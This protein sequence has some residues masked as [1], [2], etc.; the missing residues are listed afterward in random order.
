M[1]YVISSVSKQK[2][3]GLN[4][5]VNPFLIRIPVYPIPDIVSVLY[6]VIRKS[7]TGNGSSKFANDQMKPD[8]GQ[9]SPEKANQLFN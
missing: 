5:R 7:C 8:P 9:S 2:F 3:N 4:D 1:I 6:Y